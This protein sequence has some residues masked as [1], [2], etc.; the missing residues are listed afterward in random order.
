[1]TQLIMGKDL[2]LFF[3]EYAKRFEEDGAKLRFQTEHTLSFEKETEATRTKDGVINTISDGENTGEITSLAYRE[4]GGTVE[5]WRKLRD[6]YNRNA[7]VEVWQVDLGSKRQGGQGDEYD[8]EYYQGYFTSFE[9]SAPSDAQVELNAGFAID[10]NGATG[11][12]T[13]TPEQTQAVE[14]ALYEYTKIAKL[15]EE[16]AL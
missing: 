4:D 10:G 9:I 11:V 3:R 6:M 14:A 15:D 12:D 5:V 16:P 13:L 7:K 2:I 1:M 8:V